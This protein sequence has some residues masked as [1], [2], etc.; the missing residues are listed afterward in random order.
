MP[1]GAD[2][3]QARAYIPV[4]DENCVKWQIKWYP[5]QSESKHQK[6][7]ERISARTLRRGSL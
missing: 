4:D 6:V 2:Q 3:Q 5:N 7:Y 1:P